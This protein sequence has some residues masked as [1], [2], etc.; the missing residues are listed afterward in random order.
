MSE[1]AMAD[2]DQDDRLH[3]VSLRA[4]AGVHAGLAEELEI[5]VVLAHEGIVPADWPEAEGAWSD[6]LRDDFEAEG[7]LQARYDEHLAEAQARYGRR[8]PPLDE[9]LASWLDFVRGWS[10]D[11]E[12][13]ALLARLGL[14]STDVIRL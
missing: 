1:P 13:V 10:A 9:D 5:D 11:P 4:Y 2:E 14:R 3:G 12:P 8:V 7:P 6:R